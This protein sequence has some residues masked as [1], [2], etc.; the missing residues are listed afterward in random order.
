MKKIMRARRGQFLIISAFAV[1]LILTAA[2]AS[3]YSGVQDNPFTETVKLAKDVNEVNLSI[4]R[5]LGFS[6]GY[7]GS[8]LQV[9]G[10][11]TYAREKTDNYIFSGLVNLEHSSLDSASSFEVESLSIRTQWFQSVSWSRG[12]IS[13]AYTL[14]SSGLE[15]IRIS[16]TIS[17][18]V[19]MVNTIN[20]QSIVNVK[21]NGDYP[22]LSLTKENFFFYDYD[23]MNHQWNL[24]NPETEP[25]ISVEGNYILDIPSGVN[26]DVYLLEVVDD[27]GIKVEAFYSP[28]GKSEYKYTFNWNSTLY[29]G[30][31]SD[32]I[33]VEL[34][35]NGTLRW[36][37]E[38]L[39]MGNRERPIPPL[40]VS[41]IHV[42]QTIDGINKEV[43]FQI[44][45]WGSEY[46]VPLGLTYNASIF[47][48]RS[49]IVFLL[50]HHVSNTTIWW[51]GGDTANQTAYA[52]TNRYFQNDD[53]GS[54]E[55]TNGII[56]LD[57]SDSQKVNAEVNGV[58]SSLEFLRVNGREPTYGSGLSYTIHHGI[59][60]DVIQQEAE[61]AG[62]ITDCPDIYSHIVITLPANAT[63][64]TFT[65][66]TIFLQSAMTR[67]IDDLS[68]IQFSADRGA[69][70][71]EDGVIGGKPIAALSPSEFYDGG[72]AWNH[73]WS[74]YLDASNRGAGIMFRNATNARLYAF[75][76]F[77][78]DKTGALNIFQSSRKIEMNP[79]KRYSVQNFQDAYDISWNG[80]VVISG[81]G[82]PNDT[83]YPYANNYIYSSSTLY[84]GLWI[85]VEQPPTII[86][87]PA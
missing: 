78:G 83:I 65:A 7:Y 18:Q 34:L 69:A 6:V 27:R 75:D 40:I 19:Q 45:D 84:K 82:N 55:L 41:S 38:K 59:V 67:D 54:G 48:S 28:S 31:D 1:I 68:V 50:N 85:I 58:T 47:S 14:P 13:L 30:L 23:N 8:I 61:W 72:T 25:T 81:S 73:Q 24:V 64:Y 33:A 39:D 87:G 74:E 15:G 9:T 49:M 43:P 56:T 3:I 20:N 21:K 4:K 66:Q 17:L 60:R 42:N 11:A 46:T 36:L 35:Q 77:A 62:G 51:N 52:W 86:L 16:E 37:G 10:N 70:L 26:K 32:T 5:I 2:V 12:D 80:A 63:Y 53:P 29:Q 79:I 44:E 76:A 57:L 71:T 22:D